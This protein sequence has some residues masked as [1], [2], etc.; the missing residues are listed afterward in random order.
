[1]SLPSPQ[2]I[3]FDLDGTLADTAPDLANAANKLRITRGLPPV[4]YESLRPVASAGARGLIGAA[5]G[6]GPEEKD[7][8][9]LRDEFLRNYE[10]AIA[11]DSILFAG[12]GEL[13]S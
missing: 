13:L 10:T 1:M 5:F 2:A 9:A 4:A 12:V 6:I 11:V 3:L 8:L 7:Y